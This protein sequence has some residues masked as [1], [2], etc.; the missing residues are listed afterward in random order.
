MKE[1]NFEKLQNDDYKL[2]DFIKDKYERKKFC[3][4]KNENPM[5]L[6]IQG[7]SPTKS[8][9]KDKIID[10]DEKNLSR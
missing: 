8:N 6:I 10:K 2:H 7:K 4:T 1:N 9:I 3:D 5:V